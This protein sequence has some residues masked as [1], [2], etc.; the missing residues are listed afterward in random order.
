MK[1]IVIIIAYFFIVT[2]FISDHNT[3]DENTTNYR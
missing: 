3:L 2:V 1:K